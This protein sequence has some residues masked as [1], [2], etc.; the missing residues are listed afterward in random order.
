MKV[1]L[2]TPTQSGEA[3]TAVHVAENLMGK[4]HCAAFVTSPDARR[5]ISSRFLGKVFELTSDVED[6]IRVW[7]QALEAFTPDIVIFADYHIV[8]SPGLSS[9]L[10]PKWLAHLQRSQVCLVTFD[11]LG[12]G[13]CAE[14]LTIGPRHLH[15]EHVT[16]LAAPDGMRIMLPCPMHHPGPL[17]GWRGDLFRYWNLP[18]GLPGDMRRE[19]RRSYLNNEDDPL[20]M[21]SVPTWAWKMTETLQLPFYRFL[22]EILPITSKTSASR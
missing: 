1:L 18:L 20:I 4:G 11:H 2:V 5:L 7:Y 3:V 16:F 21:H 10:G 19:V 9:P 13:Q 6:N 8:A 22:S 15:S 17:E 12:F 14:E